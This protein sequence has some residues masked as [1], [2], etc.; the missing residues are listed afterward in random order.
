MPR[1]RC[2][3]HKDCEGDGGAQD[4]EL[5]CAACAVVLPHL[6]RDTTGRKRRHPDLAP[7]DPA[8]RRRRGAALAAARGHRPSQA[9]QANAGSYREDDHA[10][11]RSR[12]APRASI[13][14]R[15]DERAE[16]CYECERNQRNGHENWLC[17]F[18]RSEAGGGGGGSSS[19]T[20]RGRVEISPGRRA[21]PPL[22]PGGRT[23]TRAAAAAAERAR[24]DP[25]EIA[26]VRREARN[27]E[28][29]GRLERYRH[30]RLTMNENEAAMEV[31]G[32]GAA[33]DSSDDSSD[34]E[35][36]QMVGDLERANQPPAAAPLYNNGMDTD[37][38]NED[39]EGGAA[40]GGGGAPR[41]NNGM[42]TD[43]EEND[44]G[45]AFLQ[46]S[47]EEPEVDLPM[48]PEQA[49]MLRALRRANGET[50]SDDEDDDDFDGA[51]P[52]AAAPDAAPAVFS[53]HVA[54]RHDI[55][56]IREAHLPEPSDVGH[57][58]ERCPH[59]RAWAW[60][61]EK[62]K[63]G[64]DLWAR[65]CKH[66]AVPRPEYSAPPDALRVLI[67]MESPDSLDFLCVARQLNMALSFAST[68]VHNATQP[69]PLSDFRIQGQAA[70]RIGAVS[71]ADTN[72]AK[73]A[74]VLFTDASEAAQVNLMLSRTRLNDTAGHKRLLAVARSA[75]IDVNPFYGIYKNALDREKD[76]VARG[77]APL[78][79]YRIVFPEDRTATV[80]QGAHPGRYNGN[81]VGTAAA[82]AEVGAIWAVNGD[83]DN[84]KRSV[85][86]HLKDQRTPTP[87][88]HTGTHFLALSLFSA[89]LCRP[90]LCLIGF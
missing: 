65:C 39:D 56:G 13:V 7:C 31:Y 10:L 74:Q 28:T 62:N 25:A 14:V 58:D 84:G 43:E 55:D 69:G 26:R 19:S 5:F 20:T 44:E 83:G 42:D 52:G 48:N 75:V 73:F 33:D 49:S 71:A 45:G 81:D 85:V 32:Q 53:N 64:G 87:L 38:E 3:S 30:L 16:E 61:G 22:R 70:F 2:W 24:L 80:P 40:G 66:G 67:E 82:S 46:D 37:E 29:A 86:V 77:E 78:A 50:M 54:R 57:M 79:D 41:N 27:A 72:S 47:D 12:A 34:D 1:Q 68:V 90:S 4:P 35:L 9:S 6:W 63:G 15:V 36:R 17:F 11:R 8:G 51:A 21:G 18:H 23:G 89:F 59:C 88:P 60:K 76:R